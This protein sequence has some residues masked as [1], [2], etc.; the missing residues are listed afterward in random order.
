MILA[1][2]E[3]LRAAGTAS[4]TR[5]AD[6]RP[7][8]ASQVGVAPA[9]R[10]GHG[11]PS[12]ASEARSR[13][14][15]G[16]VLRSA[17]CVRR[18]RHASTCSPPAWS[19]TVTARS[20]R[21]CSM[22]ASPVWRRRTMYRILAASQP[23]ESGAISAVIPDTKPELV[24][25]GRNQ[26]WSLDIARLPQTLDVVLPLCLARHLPAASWAGWLPIGRTQRL[27]ATLIEPCSSKASSPRSAHPSFGLRRSDAPASARPASSPTSGSPAALSR[28]QVSDDNRSP[29]RSSRP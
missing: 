7:P 20:S 10:R 4:N 29:K 3:K 2:R 16:T 19:S 24:V 8:L 5:T 15:A 6:G 18:S 1:S 21:R 11:L 26:T 25:T 17:A 9:W 27:L 23:M 22:K 14:S 13:A 28:P 12:T